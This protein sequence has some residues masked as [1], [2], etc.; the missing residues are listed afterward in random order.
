[1]F[2]LPLVVNYGLKRKEDEASG[3]CGIPWNSLFFFVVRREA[4]GERRAF[5]SKTIASPSL[6]SKQQVASKKLLAKNL[7]QRMSVLIRHGLQTNGR[8]NVCWFASSDDPIKLF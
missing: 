1:M 8:F 6:A 5:L 4:R 7:Q 2:N 3:P